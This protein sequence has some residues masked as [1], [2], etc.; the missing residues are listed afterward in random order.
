MSH[1]ATFKIR[2]PCPPTAGTFAT[3]DGQTLLMLSVKTNENKVETAG[4]VITS[5]M[6]MEFMVIIVE[7]LREYYG[8]D[9]DSEV[10]IELIITDDCASG[11]FP[12]WL[13]V[14]RKYDTATRVASSSACLCI[15]CP[16]IPE[17]VAA[18]AFGASVQLC[19]F[20]IEENLLSGLVAA[21]SAAAK[22][23]PVE[24]GVAVDVDTLRLRSVAKSVR[25]WGRVSV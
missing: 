18:E 7:R 5:S 10:F 1:Y 9:S 2:Y 22:M 17:F 16:P 8:G 15:V 13:Q 24:R 12:P 21:A 14:P 3:G 4:R 20:H 6:T 19:I 11:T 25:A 23:I